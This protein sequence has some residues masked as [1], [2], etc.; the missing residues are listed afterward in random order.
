MPTEKKQS[1][2]NQLAHQNNKLMASVIDN[3]SAQDKFGFY[4]CGDIKTYSKLEA[5]EA[6]TRTG[7]PVRWI[8]ND[9]VFGCYNWSIEPTE[10][11]NEL[12]RQ[13]AQQLRDNYDYI[14]LVYSSGA[15]SDNILTTFINNNIKLDEVLLLSSDAGTHDK[16]DGFNKEIY[17]VAI[18][19]AQ[20]AKIK[21]PNLKIR[22]LDIVPMTTEYFSTQR[23]GLDY[24][25]TTNGYLSPGHIGKNKIRD[26]VPEW[27][28]MI[29]AGKRVVLLWGTDKPVVRGVNGSYYFACRDMGGNAVNAAEQMANVPGDF[30][31]F[32]YWSPDAV[33]L[34]IKQG[35]V[36]KNYLKTADTNTP[37]IKMQTAGAPHL[38]WESGINALKFENK[39]LYT[40]TFDGIRSIIYPNWRDNLYT[41][42]SG[43][44]VLSVRD[45]W[46]HSM[47]DT[48]EI[49]RLVKTGFHGVWNNL[50]L[51]WK[52]N[53]NNPLNGI[54]SCYSKF[55]DLGT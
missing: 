8:F 53:P 27:Q 19:R 6:E 36:I 41:Y 51:K 11:L 20:E 2:T 23:P 16:N 50:P 42:K 54:K 49:K 15:D 45:E 38:T 25:Y 29:S 4:Q 44:I 31:E 3:I 12:Y 10:S 32:F 37:F 30:N 13:R 39:Q 5:I 55:Y 52:A 46:L 7:N 34:L 9:S 26:Q 43:V 22:M 24:V 14:V 33:P 47:S 18:P 21:Q 35:H 28:R 1:Y 48:E 40:L 17:D